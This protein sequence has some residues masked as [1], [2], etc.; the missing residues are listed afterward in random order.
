M[1]SLQLL[2]FFLI[3]LLFSVFFFLEGFDYGVGMSLRVIARNERERGELMQAIGPHWDGNEVWLITAGGAMFASFPYWY[4]SLFSGF[5][6]ILF[7]TLFSLILRGVSFEF[8]AHSESAAG[9]KLWGWTLSIGSLGAPFLLG[10]MFTDLV[11]GMPLDANGNIMGGFSD[12]VNLFSIVGGVAVTLLCLLHGL[13]FIRLKLTGDLRQRA[14]AVTKVLYPVLFVGLVAFAG[15]LMWQTDFFTERP[16]SSWILLVLIVLLSVV[17]TYG[18]YRNKEVLSFIASGA[19]LIGVV[20]L[21]FNGLFPRVMVGND[22]L[23]SILISQASS[24]SYT[25]GVMTIVAAIFVPIVLAY[26]IWSYFVFNQRV[27]TKK[28]VSD[29]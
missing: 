14:Q 4:A 2:W 11:K 13:N 25:L 24:T 5:Y 1:S 16:I 15:L 22:P 20:A 18:A 6:I 19:T 23:H 8:R 7:L 12:Y 26:T 10:M 28:V 3:G 17:A 9:R 29:K 21:L 27:R